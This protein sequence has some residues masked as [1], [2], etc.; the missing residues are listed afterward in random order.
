MRSKC[1]LFA[2]LFLA[3]TVVS[4]DDPRRES[5]AD[6]ALDRI[7][8]GQRERID[9]DRNAEYERLV[10]ERLEEEVGIEN[11]IRLLVELEPGSYTVVAPNGTRRRFQIHASDVDR[12][13]HMDLGSVIYHERPDGSVKREFLRYSD[14]RIQRAHSG[15]LG[16]PSVRPKSLAEIEREKI[17]ARA[18]RSRQEARLRVLNFLWEQLDAEMKEYDKLEQKVRRWRAERETA[19]ARLE[20]INEQYAEWI[21]KASPVETLS[22]HESGALLREIDA[23]EAAEKEA[24]HDA[25]VANYMLKNAVYRQDY[26]YKNTLLPLIR[27]IEAM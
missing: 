1:F 2:V 15:E 5:A 10:R 24:I 8:E 3:N 20:L 9:S 4:A 26:F 23:I 12:R 7:D 21:A 11:P 17:V 6:R 27:K 22:A 19:F 16:M 14:R 18:K 13:E 25:S